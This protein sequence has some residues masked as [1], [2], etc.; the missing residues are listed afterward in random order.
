[1]GFD[2]R[3]DAVPENPGVYLM[4]DPSG[5]V[6]YVGKAKNLKNRLRSYFTKN[7]TGTD[8]VRA[9]ISNI[10]DFDYVVVESELEALLL[11][12]NFIKSYNP[13]YNV[14]LRDDK[15]YPYVCITMN[16]TYP[17]I[18]KAFRIGS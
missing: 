8:K 7:P 1:S 11:E 15:G 14:L 3:L 16:E 5:S 4:K 10:A 9:M 2:A 13:K 6:I 12:A 18:F 17:R